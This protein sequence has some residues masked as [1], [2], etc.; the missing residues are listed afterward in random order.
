MNLFAP[1]LFRSFAL[2]FAVGGLFLG[3]YNFDIVGNTL[4]APVNAAQPIEA[5]QPSDVFLIEPLEEAE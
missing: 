3:L 5:P 2:G 1:D 4:D